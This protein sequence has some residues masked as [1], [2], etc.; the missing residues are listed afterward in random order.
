MSTLHRRWAAR[1]KDTATE[2]AWSP[3]GRQLAVANNAGHV[4]VFDGETGALRHQWIGHKGGALS[5]AW[6]PGGRLV[7]GGQDGTVRLWTPGVE[8]PTVLAT[9]GRWVSALLWSA[10]GWI[11]VAVDDRVRFFDAVGQPLPGGGVHPATVAGMAFD[12]RSGGVVAASYG[13]GWV[14]QAGVDAAVERFD[15]KGSMLAVSP[16]PDGR[17]V[18]FGAQDASTV[19][20]DRHGGPPLR[21]GGYGGKVL[22]LAWGGSGPTLISAG[23]TTMAAWEFAGAGPSGGRSAGLPSTLRALFTR[24]SRRPMVTPIAMELTPSCAARGSAGYARAT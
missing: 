9:E 19:V 15:F 24:R 20:W 5:I 17:W 23:A 21:M 6:G 16:S 10:T 18:A 8:T 22:A 4:L 12:P 2:M 13:G 3:D 14:W 1:G 11:A 7:T